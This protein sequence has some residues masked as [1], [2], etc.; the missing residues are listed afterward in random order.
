[1]PSVS[2]SAFYE[3]ATRTMSSLRARAEALQGAIG[4]GQR[5]NAGSDDPV[6]AARLRS[7][8]RAEDFSQV[9]SAAADAASADLQLTD[10]TL[11]AFTDMAGRV[12]ELAMT[13]ANGVLNA[14]QR[15]GIA[16]EL[17]QLQ[18][19]LLRLANTRDSAGHALFGGQATGQAYTID[20]AGNAVYAGTASADSVALG[21]GQS[22]T[23]TLTGPEAFQF[24]GPSGTTDLFAVVK[25][26]TDALNGAAADPAQAARDALVP[27]DSAVETITTAQTVI[28]ARLN[29][30]DLTT[31][32]RTQVSEQNAGEQT[33]LGGA[34]IAETVSR[35]QQTMTVLEASQASFAKLAAL[36]LFDLLR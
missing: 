25:T 2:T 3:S 11:S 24:T 16:T 12:K 32:R 10:S 26:L 33:R 7:L 20:A 27:L 22:V 5:L 30:V 34:D 15:S 28:G 14:G 18:G 29:W 31:N 6:A 13:A 8:S 35:L 1:M 19:E 21:D 36:S 9:S 23:R 17:K 4:S